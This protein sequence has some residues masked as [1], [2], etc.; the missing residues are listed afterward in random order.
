MK[1][2]VNGLLDVLQATLDQG[3]LQGGA[4]I[5][6]SPGAARFAAGGLV[7]DGAKVEQAVRKLV[8]AGRTDPDFPEV[9]FNAA[10]QADVRFHTATVEIPAD[11]EE[12]RKAFG[13]Q[14]DIAVGT[15]PTSAYAAAGKDAMALL[16]QVINGSGA[17]AATGTPLDMRVSLTPILTFASQMEDDP[18]VAAM[19]NALQKTKSGDSISL[20]ARSI[21]RGV[22]Y[23]LAIQEGILSLIGEAA[24][25]SG[26][27]GAQ[28]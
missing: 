14:M 3:R 25:M 6:L 28:R 20:T 8:E 27:S 7:A 16:K 26:T 22:V 10:T 23:R 21:E 17:Q 11:E 24:R 18:T 1:E 13:P 4:A 9:Q 12:A 5:I 2:A 19:A 15:G